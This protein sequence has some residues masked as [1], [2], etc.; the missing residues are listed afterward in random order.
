MLF[1][2]LLSFV[3]YILN[4][5]ASLLS[6][7]IIFPLFHPVFCKFHVSGSDGRSRVCSLQEVGLKVLYYPEVKRFHLSYYAQNSLPSRSQVPDYEPQASYVC[8]LYLH[9]FHR[10]YIPWLRGF[11]RLSFHHNK[12]RIL[13]WH[14]RYTCILKKEVSI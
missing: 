9:R 14:Q 13:F 2:L 12:A 1:Y 11:A 7:F 4:A 6:S 10:C 5:T 8:I 3:Y